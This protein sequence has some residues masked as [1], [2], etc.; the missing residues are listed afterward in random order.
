MKEIKCLNTLSLNLSYLEKL[1]VFGNIKI[2]APLM[3]LVSCFIH[4]CTAMFTGIQCE[5]MCAHK[6]S[7]LYNPMYGSLQV[8][9]FNGFPRQECWGKNGKDGL[10][11][12]TL[13]SSQLQES[14]LHLLG[15]LYWQAVFFTP[16]Y[17]PEALY[18]RQSSDC[19]DCAISE[20]LL[21][22]HKLLNKVTRPSYFRS[23]KYSYSHEGEIKSNIQYGINKMILC[24]D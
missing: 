1:V 3:P 9:L 14:N 5:L 23:Q 17:H 4:Y 12:S 22:E 10:P 7:T 8:P 19:I 2:L 13:R 18:S 11:F 21:N 24:Q 16:L 15:L 6:C 20:Y